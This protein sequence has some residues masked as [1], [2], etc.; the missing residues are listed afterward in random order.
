[1]RSK[2]FAASELARI[3]SLGATISLLPEIISRLDPAGIG[4]F[5]NKYVLS[6]DA[7]KRY[8]VALT[9]LPVLLEIKTLRMISVDELPAVRIV[10]RALL[11][12]SAVDKLDL[13]VLVKVFAMSA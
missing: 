6:P 4:A 13:V 5:L 12:T 3:T 8:T 11:V 9:L 1:M 10:V 2:E 7:V